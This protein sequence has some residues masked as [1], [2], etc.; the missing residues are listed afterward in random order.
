MSETCGYCQKVKQW[1]GIGHTEAECKTK[2]REKE[3][4]TNPTAKPAKLDLDDSGDEG[5]KIQRL[6]VRMIK[7]TGSLRHPV[8]YEYHTGAQVHTKNEHSTQ[9]HIQE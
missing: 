8:W 6:F 7:A 2:K 9:N 3:Q 4:R 5:V 1:R